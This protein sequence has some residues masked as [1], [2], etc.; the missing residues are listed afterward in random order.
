MTRHDIEHLGQVCE[1]VFAQIN[2]S[3]DKAMK[4]D[5]F[6][7]FVDRMLW[8]IRSSNGNPQFDEQR[9]RKMTKG[10]IDGQRIF[11]EHHKD[12]DKIG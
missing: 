8:A 3:E 2:A 10:E 7:S 6:D 5:D 4:L 9:F 12:E 11:P 1:S